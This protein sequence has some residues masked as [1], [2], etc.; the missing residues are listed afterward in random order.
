MCRIVYRPPPPGGNQIAVSKYHFASYIVMSQL[1]RNDRLWQFVLIYTN[2]SLSARKTVILEKLTV[3][4][5][6]KI[7]PTF[8]GALSFITLF[9]KVRHFSLFS[10]RPIQCTASWPISLIFTLIF[11]HLSLD[12]PNSRFSLRFSHQ[13]TQKL[14]VFFITALI[15]VCLF[16]CLM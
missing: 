15:A 10:V 16:V 1:T 12:L 7:F 11:F 3:P 4:Q 9:K 8:Y 5:Q 6:V 2:T 14:G 13:K